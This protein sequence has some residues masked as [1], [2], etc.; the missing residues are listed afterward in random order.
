MDVE[1]REGER[2]GEGRAVV[3]SAAKWKEEENENIAKW[4]L[5]KV[6]LIAIKFTDDI[7]ADTLAEV[8]CF[9]FQGR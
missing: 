5:Y 6:S 7:S 4:R 8:G 3:V 9:T 2:E 1:W